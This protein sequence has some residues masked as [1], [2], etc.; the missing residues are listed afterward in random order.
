V[1]HGRKWVAMIGDG[2]DIAWL[3][4]TVV[5]PFFAHPDFHPRVMRAS[6]DSTR[7]A[8]PGIF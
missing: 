8:W 7:A 2:T 1:T 3:E 5:F 6:I 4:H